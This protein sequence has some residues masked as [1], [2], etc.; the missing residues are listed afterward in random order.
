VVREELEELRELEARSVGL[1]GPRSAT[2]QRIAS[3]R[4]RRERGSA[5]TQ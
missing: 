5:Q 4:A 3:E 2:T 1:F